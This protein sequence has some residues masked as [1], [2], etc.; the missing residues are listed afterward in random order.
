MMNPDFDSAVVVSPYYWPFRDDM[1]QT[2]HHVARELARRYP[3]VYVEP[4]PQWDPRSDQF[5]GYVLADSLFGPRHAPAST[6]L[7]VFRRRGLPFGSMRCIRNFDLRRNATVLTRYLKA[8]AF[9]RTLVWHSFPYWSRMIVDAVP[10]HTLAYHCLD[11]S[12]R[13]EEECEL[14]KRADAVFCVSET[15]VEKHRVT[16]WN[17]HLLPNGVDLNLF[18]P[19]RAEQSARPADLPNSGGRLIGFVGCLNSHIDFDLLLSVAEHF[20]GDHLVLIGR[21]PRRANAPDAEQQLALSRLRSMP[22]VHFL[23]FKHTQ[24]LPLYIAAFDACLIPFKANRFNRECDPLKF[25]QYLAMGSPVVTTGVC[26]AERYPNVSY[27]ASTPDEFISAVNRALNEVDGGRMRRTRR[28]LASKHSWHAI[29]EQA[30]SLVSR[31]A[32]AQAASAMSVH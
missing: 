11:Y 16:N 21:I 8:L 18:D 28:A 24:E 4:A 3:T 14:V 31:A 29:V 2:T 9:K 6:N 22:N 23:G 5:R 25:Y 17:T 27:P 30:L 10:Y 19:G 12:A 15:L 20:R 1:W 32:E 26:V 13:T 7:T